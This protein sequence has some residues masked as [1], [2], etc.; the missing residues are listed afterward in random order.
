MQRESGPR[1]YHTLDAGAT[2]ARPWL[3]GRACGQRPAARGAPHSVFKVAALRGTLTPQRETRHT[4]TPP[5]SAHTKAHGPW[6]RLSPVF[7]AART[8]DGDP[9]ASSPRPRRLRAGPGFLQVQFHPECSHPSRLQVQSPL[10]T[11]FFTT[12][13]LPSSFLSEAHWHTRCPLLL[14]GLRA[15]AP[16]FLLVPHVR[17]QVYRSVWRGA[18]LART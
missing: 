6:K 18:P 15:R 14:N 9:R 17:A 8:A 5:G 11:G 12:V 7:T 3:P 13:F 16:A 2:P 4:P 10:W 1:L